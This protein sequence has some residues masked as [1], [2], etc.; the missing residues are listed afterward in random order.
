MRWC[1]FYLKCTLLQFTEHQLKNTNKHRLNLWKWN[2]KT[3]QVCIWNT[4]YMLI[5]L[6]C[7]WIHIQ[8]DIICSLGISTLNEWQSW[9]SFCLTPNL[10]H[11]PRHFW[12][13]ILCLKPHSIFIFKTLVKVC[14]FQSPL[15]WRFVKIKSTFFLKMK[16]PWI[17][18]KK[19]RCRWFI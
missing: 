18:R 4:T 3:F 19:P 6:S 17:S 1:R 10:K 13:S 5:Y 7:T 11:F 2:T 14:V 12:L 16:N 8:N 15:G 9:M